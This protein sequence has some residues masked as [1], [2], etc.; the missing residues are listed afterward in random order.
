MKKIVGLLFVLCLFSSLYVSCRSASNKQTAYDFNPLDSIINSWMDKDYYPGGA[1]CVMRNDSVLFEK[2]YKGFTTDTKVYVASAGKWVAAATIAAVVDCSS[3]EWDDV[4]KEWIPEFN[5][6][7][8]GDIPLRNLLSHTSGVR[9]Y[10]PEPR[11]DDY[12]HLDSAMLEILPLDTLFAYGARFEYGGLAMQI[13]GRMAEKAMDEEFE[14]IFQRM[15]AAPLEMKNSHFVPVN[16]D[17]GHAP[18]LGG[19]LCTTLEDYIKFLN[20]ISHNGMYQGKQIIK[21]ETVLEMQSDQVKDAIVASGEYVER[22]LGEHH[23]GIYGLGEWRELVDNNTGEA[24]QISSPG[25]AGAYPWINKKENVY[26][27]FIA[28]VNGAANKEDGFSSFYGSPIISK[29][30][31]MILS[32]SNSTSKK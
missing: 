25:W 26:G 31:S 28:H 23:S 14:K 7:P 21:P 16:R 15:I 2:C 5:G 27:F 10:L 1:I 8:K 24:Y 20:M 9:P 22:G 32:S 13:A 29:T 18:M 19:G 11:V 3:L 6:D 17:G 12:N 30:V 4:V